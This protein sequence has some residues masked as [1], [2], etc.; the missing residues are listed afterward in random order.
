MGAMLL[1]VAIICVIALTVVFRNEIR[2]LASIRQ[3]DDYGMFQMTYFGVYGFDDFLLVGAESDN[4][5]EEFVSERLLRGI[6]FRFDITGGG[7]TVFVTR[8]FEGEVLFGR[9]FDFGTYSPPMQLITSPDNGYA[10]ISTVNLQF[11]GYNE[12]SLPN[13]LNR[14]S[15]PALGAPYV[16]FD[17][18]NEKGVA[19]ALLAI[20][21]AEPPF[22]E[23][24][25]MLGTTTA[26]R[27]VLDKA[28]SVDEAVDLLR[29]YNMYFSAGIECQ[30]LI[31][32]ASG[33]SV[34]VNYWDGELRI[35]E[36]AENFQVATNFIPYNDLNIGEGFDE[37]ERYDRVMEVI[38]NKGGILN[39]KQVID[40]LAEVGVRGDNGE[41]RLQWTVVYN[42]S[43]LEGSIFANRNT[44]NLIDFQLTPIGKGDLFE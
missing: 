5:V 31:A 37:F 23:G 32:D 12:N 18:M 40:V 33:R 42:L 10:S 30:F 38:E 13:G 35:T 15:F 6:P 17:G 3:V 21:E 20:P 24:R 41:N 27:L 19:I 8:N 43:T 44:D 9:N 36:T 28:A 22:Y 7:C 16:P 11:L 4:D 39:K 14:R 1:S 2:S 25:I 26:I 29:Q 34:V